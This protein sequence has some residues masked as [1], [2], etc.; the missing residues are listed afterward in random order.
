[1]PSDYAFNTLTK[2][3]DDGY[4]VLLVDLLGSKIRMFMVTTSKESLV[5]FES[6][7]KAA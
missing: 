1:M 6:D 2:Y 3:L 5:E 4:S 7:I